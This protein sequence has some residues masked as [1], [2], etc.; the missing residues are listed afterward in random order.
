MMEFRFLAV[1]LPTLSPG[2]HHPQHGP[3]ARAGCFP[4]DAAKDS[5]GTEYATLVSCYLNRMMSTISKWTFLTN[6]AHVL[7]CIAADPKSL[8]REVAKSVGITER[9][10]Q[11]IVAELAADGYLERRRVGRRNT[12]RIH[13]ELHLRHPVEEHLTVGSLIDLIS[14]GTEGRS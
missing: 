8:L 2:R 6:H 12:Y 5:A 3:G 4:V 7:L 10:T 11:R 13:P 14:E 9:A 1:I